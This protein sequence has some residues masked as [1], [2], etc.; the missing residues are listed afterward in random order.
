MRLGF[1]GRCL[2]LITLFLR[3]C[4]LPQTVAAFL[5]QRGIY[6]RKDEERNT[7]GP[8]S[9]HNLVQL[10]TSVIPLPCNIRPHAAL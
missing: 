9:T 3:Y 7:T 1:S 10:K 4:K 2:D 6:Q 8:S 5:C